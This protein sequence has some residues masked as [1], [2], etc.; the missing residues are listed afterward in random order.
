MRRLRR[1]LRDERGVTA[2][3]VALMMVPLI[4][5]LAISVDV[6]ALYGERAQLQNGADAAALA[7]AISCAKQLPSCA[8]PLQIA[9]T[10]ADQNAIDGATTAL[11]P[12][13]PNDHTVTVSVQSLNP[14]GSSGVS[15]PF[16]SL[17]GIGSTTVGA[18]ATAE[19]GSLSSGGVLPLALAYCAFSGA[20][21]DT[22]ILVQYDENK[23]CK[24]PIGQPIKGGFGWLDQL[25]GQ[26]LSFIDLAQPNVGS[27]PGL[28]PPSNCTSIFSTLEGK[29]VLI[30]IYDCSHTANSTD[31]ANGTNGQNGVFHIYS[32]AAF[33]ITGWK[34]T[35]NGNSIMN[36]P[37][38]LAPSCTGNCRGVQGYFQQYVYPDALATWDLGGPPTGLSVVRLTN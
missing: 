28:D 5:C 21:F 2:V 38:P 12:T 24:G 18:S 7:V 31:C 11:S 1:R 6:G 37:D 9:T 32:F 20:A 22:R 36:N 27:N 25:P 34:F 14:D 23:P 10:I 17:L 4:G 35:G 15:H 30:P 19:W 29:T 16:A 13:F 8:T 26:C 33:K 3:L